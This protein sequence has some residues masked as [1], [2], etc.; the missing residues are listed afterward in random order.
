MNTDNRGAIARR[1]ARRPRRGASRPSRRPTPVACRE[2]RKTAGDRAGTAK[3]G[4]R[5]GR[6]GSA[7]AEEGR[8]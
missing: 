4:W 5:R 2:H 8:E 3:P 1:R 6:P 7:R